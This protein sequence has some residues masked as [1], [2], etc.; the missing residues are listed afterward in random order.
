MQ[1]FRD[2]R[3]IQTRAKKE[4]L[5]QNP[6]KQK[7]EEKQLYVYFKQITKEITLKMAKKGQYHGSIYISFDSST[8]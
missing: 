3:N 4:S 2:S 6:K 7:R 5:Q 1:H 8:E